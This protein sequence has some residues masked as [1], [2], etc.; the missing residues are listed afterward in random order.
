MIWNQAHLTAKS[1]L[2]PAVILQPHAC[3]QQVPDPDWVSQIDPVWINFKMGSSLELCCQ[4]AS[5]RN[6]Y[7]NGQFKSLHMS[8]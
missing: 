2:L 6:S 7:Q 5:L 8:L 4:N 3:Q 1:M